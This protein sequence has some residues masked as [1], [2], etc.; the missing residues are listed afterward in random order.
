MKLLFAPISIVSGRLAGLTARRLTDRL[1]SVV[2][3]A[4]PPRPEQRAA[5]WPKLAAGLAV[6]GAVF[7][8]VSG[9]TDHAARQWFA[10]FTGRWPGEDEHVGASE[11]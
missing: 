7:A 2:D 6:E 5:A 11:A 1:W 3:D 4:Q 9:L 8:V 10:S